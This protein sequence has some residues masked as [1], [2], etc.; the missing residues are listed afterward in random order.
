[1]TGFD[2]RRL[3]AS[4][5]TLIAP[6]SLPRPMYRLP[7]CG[8]RCISALLIPLHPT[9]LPARRGAPR[10]PIPAR[11]DLSP[12]PAPHH[13]P[14][15]CRYVVVGRFDAPFLQARGVTAIAARCDVHEKSAKS[16]TAISCDTVSRAAPARPFL[17]CRP[18]PRRSLSG[19]ACISA[20]ENAARMAMPLALSACASRPLRPRGRPHAR[21]AAANAMLRAPSRSH[22]GPN[23]HPAARECEKRQERQQPPCRRT[24]RF[25]A[26]TATSPTPEEQ[27]PSPS[28]PRRL[29]RRD[30]GSSGAGNVTATMRPAPARPRLAAYPPTPTNPG[31]NGTLRRTQNAL[32]RAKSGNKRQPASVLPPSRRGGKTAQASTEHAAGVRGAGGEGGATPIPSSAFAA[33]DST[34]GRAT[35]SLVKES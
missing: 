23:G 14:H 29:R 16:A 22:S 2:G 19:Y 30:S 15:D 26:E 27:L 1:M 24:F 10:A 35:L 34:V 3:S 5:A 20:S 18:S 32:P 4:R 12:M 13:P 6:S 33:V 28:V 25:P 8:L 9:R 17:G 7:R 21:S 11:Q 31:G